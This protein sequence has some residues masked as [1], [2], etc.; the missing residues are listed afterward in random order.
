MVRRRKNTI[1]SYVILVD[2][3]KLLLGGGGVPISE[4]WSYMEV[5]Q[6]RVRVPPKGK[7]WD[8]MV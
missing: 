4:T 3:C 5:R 2:L 7:G 6:V 1:G 8:G